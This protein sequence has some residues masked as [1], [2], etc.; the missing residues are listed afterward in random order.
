VSRRQ[1]R[2]KLLSKIHSLTKNTKVQ[3]RELHKKIDIQ[4]QQGRKDA[5]SLLL[6][7]NENT[8]ESLERRTNTVSSNPTTPQYQTSTNNYRFV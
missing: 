6:P 2:K 3:F 8:K 4:Q 1:E 5:A 7:T